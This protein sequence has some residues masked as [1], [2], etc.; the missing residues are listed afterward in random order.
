MNNSLRQLAL[1][2]LDDDQGINS[3]AW[4]TLSDMLYDDEQNDIIDAVKETEGRIYL[5]SNAVEALT[6]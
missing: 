3:R 2:L 1:E 4:K 6:N 5:T